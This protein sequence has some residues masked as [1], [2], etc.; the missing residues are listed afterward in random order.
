MLELEA[1]VDRILAAIPPP[2]AEEIPVEQC[3]GRVSINPVMASIDLPVFDN[4]AMDGY[5]VR[6]EDLHGASPANPARLQVCGRISAGETFVGT[7]VPR[8]CVRIFTGAPMPAEA[9]AVVMQEDTRVCP[10]HAGLIEV[11]D[12]VEP[13]ENVRRRGED[14][15]QGEVIAGGGI[16]LAAAHIAVLAA[17]GVA[18]IHVGRQP[19]IGILATGSEL[20]SPGQPL[21]PGYIYESNRAMLSALVAETGAIP[22]LYPLVVDT[23]EATQSALRQALDESDAVLTSGG[24]SVGEFDFIKP[25]FAEMGGEI[26]FWK[27]S[28][29]PGRPFVFGRVE[30]KLLFGVPG[31]PVSAY[32]TFLLLVRPALLHWQGSASCALFSHSA[33]LAD[34][35][36]NPGDRR[37]F[38]RVR[39][40]SDGT[41]SSAGAQASHCVGSLAQSNGLLDLAPGANLAAGAEVK[42]I[43]F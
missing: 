16:R 25:V 19:R 33:L 11:L 12:V 30:G 41:V 39:V 7:V 38:L 6:S 21:K 20:L 1:A 40:N 9:D 23:A 27:V 3:S 8:C 42:V 37:H 31:N 10:D 17:T 4:S 13:G 36:S 28:M 22:C 18:R 24:V 35:V 15:K 32:V 43:R 26:G 29:K 34:P 5:A 2:V 14:V